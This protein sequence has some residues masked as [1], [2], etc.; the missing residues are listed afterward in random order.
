MKSILL[1]TFLSF[2]SI[3]GYSQNF[4][5]NGNVVDAD[6]IPLPGVTILVKNT[7]KGA[8]TDF[9]GNFT[10][11]NVQNGEILV[12]S[13]IGFTTKEILV[14]DSNFLNVTLSEDTESL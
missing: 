4:E 6:G 11:S 10:I 14:S 9:D 12:F 13:Y 8:S 3:F 7:T 2:A 5:I 1:L